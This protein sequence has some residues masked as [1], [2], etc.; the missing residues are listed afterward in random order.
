M[1]RFWLAILV[2]TTLAARASAIDGS[3]L[4]LNSGGTA[5]AAAVLNGNG[6]AGSY[7]T[8]A[9][10]GD[11]TINVNAAGTAAGGLAPRM[12]IVIADTKVPFDVAAGGSNYS[13][14]FSSLPAGTYFV[15]TEFTNDG[16]TGRS[17]SINSFDVSG[18]T[19]DTA[20]DE[21]ALR[22]SALAAADTYID[23]YRQGPGKVALVGVAPGTQVQVKLTNHAFN[24]GTNIHGVADTGLLVANPIPGS[25]AAKYQEFV[26][27]NFNMVEGSNA[28]KWSVNEGTR[29][30]SVASGMDWQDKIFDFAD[31]NGMKKRMHAL[32]W[33][34]QQPNWVT[35]MLNNPAAT[36]TYNA[37]A[38]SQ[39]TNLSNLNAVYSDLVAPAGTPNAGE[40]SEI[41]ERIQYYVAD[42]AQRY[43]EIDVYNESYHT[44]AQGGALSIWNR[45]GPAGVAKI[46]DDVRAAVEQAGSTARIY[47]NEYSVLENQDGDAY[48]NWYRQNIEA[49]ENGDGDPF[50]HT[51]SGIGIQYYSNT[52]HSANVMMKALQNL[53]VFDLPMTLTEFGVQG[54]G[55]LAVTNE[56]D[57]IRNM[58]EAHRM[59][60]GT[61]NATGFLYWG[62]WAS[63]TDPT[64]QGS[65]VLVDANWNLTPIGQAWKALR[66]S[67]TTDVTA[68]VGPDGTLDFTGFY[69]D[70]ELSIGGQTIDMSLVKGDSQYSLVVAA[71]DYNADG[72]VDAADYTVWRDTF[73]STSD[74]RADGNGNELIDDGDFDV[75]KSLVGTTYPGAGSLAT[76]PEPSTLLLLLL[77]SAAAIRSIAT[78]RRS[79]NSPARRT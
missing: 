18:A 12:N 65:G 1:I 74:L 16:G 50:D 39:G 57:K 51:V 59:L 55:S 43:T 19:L 64:L 10:P 56:A 60:F 3:A 33:G 7:I 53:S 75:W 28:G 4:Q 69:G 79:G 27:Q 25:N 13:H 72:V 41:D 54:A 52:G 45:Y 35:S 36:D 66:D 2:C 76:V 73:G 42:R 40:P 6:Y 48:A 49:I 11:V 37:V 78:R 15:R 5:G 61:P 23:H 68:T 20:T 34:T 62:W 21:T 29:D 67:W 26:K 14:T 22:A 8:L 9:E 77:G 46:Y 17:L 71:G 58:T 38:N 47:T 44:G 32:V 31:A 63:A 24:W 30:G 70:Y